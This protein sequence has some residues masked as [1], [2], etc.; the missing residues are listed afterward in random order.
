[1]K[2]DPDGLVSDL[3][4]DSFGCDDEEASGEI[5]GT[6]ISDEAVEKSE[7]KMVRSAQHWFFNLQ[8]FKRLTRDKGP[9][10]QT[11]CST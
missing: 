2:L 6:P 4:E 1:M 5:T 10:L 7:P 11:V 8:F 9:L 3:S